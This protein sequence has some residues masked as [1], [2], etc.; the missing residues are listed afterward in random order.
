MVVFFLLSSSLA[1][2]NVKGGNLFACNWKVPACSGASLLT[3]VFGSF[4]CL[5]LELF[6]LQLKLLY[7]TVEKCV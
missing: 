6:F 1:R 2:S 7:L 3:V 4:L 5:Q